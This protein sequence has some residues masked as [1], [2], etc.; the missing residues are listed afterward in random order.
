VTYFLIALIAG[1]VLIA[2]AG[3]LA[4]TALAASYPKTLS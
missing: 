2:L 3:A 1:F 4:I